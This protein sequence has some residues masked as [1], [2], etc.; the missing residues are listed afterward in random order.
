MVI[1]S[2][3]QD[4][5]QDFGSTVFGDGSLRIIEKLLIKI[6]AGNVLPAGKEA[7]DLVP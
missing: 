4:K 1:R 7:Y 3:F 5:P 2:A 6:F